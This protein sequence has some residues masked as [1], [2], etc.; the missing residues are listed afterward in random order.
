MRRAIREHL[1]DVIAIAALLFAGLLVT[2]YVLSQQA[3]PYPSWIPILGDDRFELKAELSTA[4]AVTPGQ[5]QTVNIA[6]VKAGEISKVELENGNAVVTMLIEPKYSSLLHSNT[7]V[8][9]RPRTGLQDMTLEVHPGQRGPELEEGETISLSQ[10]EP[11][12]NPD[13][14]L[15]ALDADTRAY[16]QLLLQAGGQGLGGHG[17]ELSATL[18]RFEPLG[19][20]LAQIGDALARR[21]QNIAHVITSFKELSEELASTDT[22]LSAWVRSQ[23]DVFSA[24][25][26]QEAS[27][28]ATLREFP[29]ALAETRRA[30]ESGNRLSLVLGPASRELIP[31]ARAFKPAQEA[32]QNL[33][34]Q[35][36]DPIE[37]QIRPFTRQIAT[38]IKH[39]RQASGPLA[40]TTN[41]LGGSLAELNRLFN[42]LAYNPPGATEGYLYWIAW[43]NH[44]TNNAFLEDAEGPMIRGS[45]LQSCNT[46]INAEAFASARPFI[47]TLQ[48]VSNVPE[49]ETICPLDPT[50]PATPLIRP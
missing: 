31:T 2:V 46:A 45:V 40:K 14:I 29:S 39:V 35:T 47:R 25:A 1:R 7:T 30:L 50:T 5:G 34:A 9:L 10:T 49:S 15:A 11:N 19:R 42:G 36:V 44:N 13:Q 17:Q 16:L 22:Q 12:V 24:F 21:R 48:Q 28:R 4:Q 37:A 23:N 3:Q 20:Y 32:A 18:R 26:D 8:L 41:E 6:G 38:P 33:F 43:G 27:I